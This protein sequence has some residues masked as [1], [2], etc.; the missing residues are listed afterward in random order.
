[1]FMFQKEIQI[2]TAPSTLGLNS[3]GVEK[4]PD[5]LLSRGLKEKLNAKKDLIEVPTYNNLRSPIRDSVT[6]IINSSVQKE[7]LTA[8]Q[9]V[10]YTNIQS[11][12]SQFQ[13]V[14]GGDCSV[15]IG[16]MS[17]LKAKGTYGLFFLDA[18]ADFYEPE[19]STTGEAADM[20]LAI[21]T[22]RGP[23]LLNDAQIKP[24]YVKDE[25][26]FHIGQRDLEETKKFGSQDIRSTGIH[27]FDASFIE[28]QGTDTTLGLIEDSCEKTST[29][30]FW[31]HFDTDVLCDYV[32]PAVDYRLPDGLTIEMSEKILSGLLNRYPVVGMSITIFNPALDKDGKIA[33]HLT[34]SLTQIFN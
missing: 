16:I 20:D 24:P 23:D 11:S 9:K 33:D 22:G 29:D 25:H 17:A 31:I 18:H 6:N 13:L 10:I 4:L 19:K 7:F 30:G 28:A 3:T 32:N 1:M 5:A 8:L 14:L 34:E 12:P 26:V 2:I 15:L 27:C 21:I